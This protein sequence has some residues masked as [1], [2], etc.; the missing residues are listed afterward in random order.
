MNTYEVRE[1]TG[2][3][4]KEAYNG[5]VSHLPKME[6]SFE[7]RVLWSSNYENLLS[8]KFDDE[9]AV[10]SLVRAAK[11]SGRVIL[12]AGAG[13]G[14]SSILLQLLRSAPSS[15]YPIFIDLAN[16]RTEAFA[17]GESVK[18]R[19]SILLPDAARP[20]IDE[21]TLA[22]LPGDGL[23]L[24][25]VDGLSEVAGGMAEDVLATLDAFARRN[26]NAGCIVAD[27][28]TRRSTPD[29]AWRLASVAPLDDAQIRA[30][31]RQVSPLLRSPLFLD[32]A[33]KKGIE[34]TTESSTFR[35]YFRDTVGLS[36]PQL[37]DAAKAA[38]KA[39][40]DRPSR[41]F[42][43]S[44][45]R[46]EVGNEAMDVLLRTGAVRKGRDVDTAF[47]SHQLFHDYLGSVWFSERPDAWDPASFNAL[48]FK[49]ASF[50][51]LALTLE[52]IEDRNLAED[53]LRRVYDW[54]FYGSGYALARVSARQE[55][56]V[57]HD[58]ETALLAMLAERRWDL[59]RATALRVTD[60]LRLFDTDSAKRWLEARNEQEVYEIVSDQHFDSEAFREWRDLFLVAP[61]TP[62]ADKIVRAIANEDSLMGWTAANVLKRVQ[63]SD[64][65]AAELRDL[66]RDQNKTIR[67][68]VAHALGAH[69]SDANVDS[70][71]YALDDDDEWV[72]YGAI[73][74]LIESAARSTTVRD[75]VI[76]ELRR[77]LPEIEA[78]PTLSWGLEHSL[79]LAEPPNEWPDVVAP[80]VEELWAQA[81]TVEQQDRWRRA[82]HR[83]LTASGKV[84]A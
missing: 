77:R 13:A 10:L 4:W 59:I 47:F 29:D 42:S 21:A 2:R 79:V 28:L 81:P 83:I 25:L 20:A 44:S 75:R 16:M 55:I 73:R 50:D 80:L 63:L 84:P 51:V 64:E 54:N 6:P 14:K 78:T 71:V 45:F 72:K 34:T 74:S 46:K 18:Q 26:P 60:A 31:S 33:I 22:A 43:L 1:A 65:Q 12:H 23:R 3:S 9:T 32:L 67:W 11:D 38:F 40:L 76:A 82:A 62:A 27:R 37:M 70:L 49:A 69:P 61:S 15:T 5:V 57:S 56:A 30:H 68:R 58:M 48:T 8:E 36:Q 24:L 52:Q 7:F 66:L 17:T 53:F 41:T 19:L 35:R 39:Y